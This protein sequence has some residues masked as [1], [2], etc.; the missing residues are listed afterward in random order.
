V[1]ERREEERRGDEGR[2][3][4]EERKERR[5]EGRKGRM[6]GELLSLFS[7][8]RRSLQPPRISLTSNPFS[9]HKCA[10]L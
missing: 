8:S 7:S 5:S 2:V 6:E 1:S 10:F 4:G 9:A 3:G